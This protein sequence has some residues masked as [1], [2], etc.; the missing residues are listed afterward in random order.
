[1]TKEK[2]N[3]EVMNDSKEKKKNVAM[4]RTDVIKEN[5]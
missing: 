2:D 5:I 3:S 1:M 4:I